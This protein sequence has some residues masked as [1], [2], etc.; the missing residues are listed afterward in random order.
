MNCIEL[1]EK[2][3]QAIRLT[4]T[5][6]VWGSGVEREDGEA[7]MLESENPLCE[8]IDSHARGGSHGPSSFRFSNSDA[9]LVSTAIG[10]LRLRLRHY[11]FLFRN[12]LEAHAGVP[13]GFGS[14]IPNLRANSVN[15][16]NILPRVQKFNSSSALLVNVSG[17]VNN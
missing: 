8:G 7:E 16:S 10:R 14:S 3:K 11:L 6:G 4:E 15:R 13:E 1:I 17:Y 12:S 5:R 9:K 2:Q